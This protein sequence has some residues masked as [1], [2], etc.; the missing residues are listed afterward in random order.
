MMSKLIWRIWLIR[1]N[2]GLNNHLKK[3]GKAQEM[4]KQVPH[5][6]QQRQM[7]S[8]VPVDYKCLPQ[9]QFWSSPA[10]MQIVRENSECHG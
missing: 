10:G 9:V 6:V 5:E 8:H 7:P 1:W 2:A 4:R 3:C